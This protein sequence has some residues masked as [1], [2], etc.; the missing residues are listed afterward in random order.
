MAPPQLSSN[1]APILSLMG[2]EILLL[3][4]FVG[5]CEDRAKGIALFKS[6]ATGG[7]GTLAPSSLRR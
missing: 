5:V 2:A 3:M 4:A 7:R 1:T 6:L